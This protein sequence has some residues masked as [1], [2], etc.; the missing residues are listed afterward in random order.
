MIGKMSFQPFDPISKVNSQAVGILAL[1]IQRQVS[2]KSLLR[3]V[4]NKGSTGNTC[5][6]IIQGSI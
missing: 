6:D 2:K 1:V 5:I 3:G 4:I